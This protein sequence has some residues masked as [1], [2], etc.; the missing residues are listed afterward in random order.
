MEGLCVLVFSLF[1]AVSITI[2]G[3]VLI[4]KKDISWQIHEWSL[5]I[6]RP[7]RT[8]EWETSST[9]RGVFLFV[10]GLGTILILIYLAVQ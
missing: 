1:I 8:P 3:L 4:F 2:L 6:Y 10:F 7:Q 5:R 9:V